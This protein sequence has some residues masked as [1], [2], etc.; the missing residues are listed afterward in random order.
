MH[1][2][3]ICTSIFLPF[4]IGLLSLQSRRSGLSLFQRLINCVTA[5]IIGVACAIAAVCIGTESGVV[6]FWRVFVE[7]WKVRW[8]HMSALPKQRTVSAA[9]FQLSP[10]TPR[11]FTKGILVKSQVERP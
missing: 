3:I 9:I 5:C 11:G 1:H 8:A 7:E 6:V 2:L 4:F 10:E